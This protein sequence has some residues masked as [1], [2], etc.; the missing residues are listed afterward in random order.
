MAWIV[1]RGQRE[2]FNIGQLLA[3]YGLLLVIAALAASLCLD[4]SYDGQWYHTD[5]ILSLAQ[6]WNPVQNPTG[7]SHYAVIY[8]RGA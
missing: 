3:G 2:A 8:P 1:W 6:G 4:F 5:A 7:S